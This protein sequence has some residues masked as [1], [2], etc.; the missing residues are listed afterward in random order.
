M[1]DHLELD[2]TILT[3]DHR[4]IRQQI[5]RFVQDEILP[6]A[7]LWEEEGRVPAA[8]FERLGDVGLLSLAFPVECGGLG[9]GPLASVVLNEELGRSGY[10]GLTAS[11][12]VQTDMTALH[13]VRAGSEE[14]RARF[15]P[16]ILAGRRICSL[17]VT[18]PL[19]GSDLTRIATTAVRSGDHYVLNGRKTF[20]TNANISDIFFIVAKTDPGARG[21]AG[22]SLFLVERNT[23]GFSNGE[24]FRKTG[25]HSS[26]TGELYFDDLH[27]PAANLLG[28]EGKGFY[29][30]MAGLDHERICAAAQA[31]GL[32]EA[33]LDAT[34]AWLKQ[35][36]AYQG[37]LWDLQVLRQNV[38]QLT[39][40]LLAARTL[41]Y[42]AAAKANRGANVQLEGA[43]L[44]G[45][46]PELANR[47]AYK[48]V[49]YH[50]GAGYISG[51]DVE[52]IA[53]DARIL[54]IGGGA[55]E[56]MFDE[57]AKRL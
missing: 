32:A 16:D 22:F 50:G 20:I 19:G 17:G 31:V 53:R 27:V 11:I 8:M 57:V 54:S 49:Q 24:R 51:T 42:A 55:S 26:D 7:G 9:L 23:P 3:E 48:C 41:T 35:R 10:G 4:V 38:A 6:V 25:W 36:E 37:T 18:E 44:K 28:E 21:G 56:V 14:Q 29:Y 45:Y 30:M 52:R 33:A 12:S 46:V 1:K 39:T 2:E 40:E 34:L 47:I 43:M 15:L 5:Q 13:L